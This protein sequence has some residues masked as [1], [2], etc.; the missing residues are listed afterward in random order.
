MDRQGLTFRTISS[1]PGR[2]QMASV[3]VPPRSIAIRAR[4]DALEPFLTSSLTVMMSYTTV[5]WQELNINSQRSPD[6][7][8]LHR[9]PGHE[10]SPGR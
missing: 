4:G 3:K 5:D 2:E 9:A 7:P 6:S 1:W 10:A 8:D